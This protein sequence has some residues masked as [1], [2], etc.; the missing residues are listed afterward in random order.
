MRKMM[1]CVGSLGLLSWTACGSEN[2]PAPPQAANAPAPVAALP[3]TLPVGQF[4]AF[5]LAANTIDGDGQCLEVGTIQRNGPPI[6]AADARQLLT[7]P[8]HAPEQSISTTRCPA[9]NRV[10][11]SCA[12]AMLSSVNYYYATG[13]HAM[14][15]ASARE[16][17]DRNMGRWAE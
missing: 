14:T 13:S 12:I 10:P 17:C 7:G 1:V 3:N 9:S 11:G 2:V 4:G 6:S 8:L 16:H 15:P 5:Q